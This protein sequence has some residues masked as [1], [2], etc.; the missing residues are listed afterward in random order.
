MRADA[1]DANRRREILL[2]RNFT[3]YLFGRFCSAM[4]MTALRAAVAWH[5]FDLS[6]SAFHLGLIGLVQFLPALFLTLIGGAVADAYD[7]R[8][9]CMVAHV[10]PLL[11][12]GV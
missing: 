4:A 11:C 7:R 10:M 12:S 5:V 9:V 6:R 8:K 3:A 1:T 2:S